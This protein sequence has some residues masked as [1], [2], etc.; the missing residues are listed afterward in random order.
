MSLQPQILH[1]EASAQVEGNGA[2]SSAVVYFLIL[3]LAGGLGAPSGIAALPIGYFLKDNLHLSP[4]EM[5]WFVAI[6]GAPACVGFL[7][8]FARDRFRPRSMGDRAY[9]LVGALLAGVAYLYLSAT[10]I[11]YPK[12][13]YATLTMSVAYVIILAAGQA[14]MTGVAQERLM[15]GLLSVVSGVGTYVP[16]VLSA[17]MGGW[18]VANVAPAVTFV[19]AA[20]MTAVIAAQAFWRQRDVIAFETASIR[21]ESGFAAIARLVRYRPIWPAA[22][23][24]F[25]WNFGPGW[26]T[27]M[28]YH[29]TETVKVSSEL[30]GV[31]T[32]LQWL[33]F[34]PS[35]MLYAPLCRRFTL[36]SLLWWGTIV[37]VAQGPLMFFAQTPASSIVVAVLYG[38]FGGFPTSVYVDL[39]IRSCPKGLE[40][41]AMMLAVTTALTVATNSGN[42]LGSW[43][44]ARGG[45]ASAVI[46]TT[47][48]SAAIIPVLWWVPRNVTSTRE[49]EA[50]AL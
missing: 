7:V 15:T 43:I 4:V 6:T 13:L 16:A 20:T 42:L 1:D 41:T 2:S 14:I 8:G 45:F 23:I 27:P 50:P 9:L 21:D 29:L 49:G 11:T 30:F 44:F 32:A 40:G 19:V 47:L 24:F 36:A 31:F 26:G 33:F 34:I 12:L 17:I 22:A 3:C 25:L 5:A 46:I 48:A 37:A 35:A 39:I 10:S 28:F 38:I 18:L